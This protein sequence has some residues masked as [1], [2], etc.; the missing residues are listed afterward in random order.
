MWVRSVKDDRKTEERELNFGKISD[1]RG[2]F[3]QEKKKEKGRRTGNAAEIVSLRRKIKLLYWYCQCQD[4][5]GQV[6]SVIAQALTVGSSAVGPDLAGF[7][8]G[9]AGLSW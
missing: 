8:R 7:A 9:C 3:R 4:P 2:A 5:A 6:Q 1:C